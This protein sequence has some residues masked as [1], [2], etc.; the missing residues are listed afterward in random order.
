MT[1][2]RDGEG[3]RQWFRGIVEQRILN[4]KAHLD[5]PICPQILRPNIFTSVRGFFSPGQDF[6]M[7]KLKL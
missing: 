3:K 5:I 7:W 4:L 6:L 2:V 1:L